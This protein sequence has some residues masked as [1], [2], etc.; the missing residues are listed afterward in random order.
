MQEVNTR[1]QHFI[2]NEHGRRTMDKYKREAKEAGRETCLIKEERAHGK[3]VEVGRG[4]T[5]GASQ[6]DVGV[7]VISA[8][9]G[10]YKTVFEK[11]GQIREHAILAK[12]Q[13]DNKLI[14]VVNKMDD[15]TVDWNQE[16]YKK[17]TELLLT[18]SVAKSATAKATSCLS[19][20]KPRLESKPGYLEISHLSIMVRRS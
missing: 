18:S 12:T 7:L 17:C 6:A 1:G 13:G 4:F 11:G 20:P 5:A 2:R 19:R 16:R 10:E 3:T 14:V 8:R 9:K 15:L